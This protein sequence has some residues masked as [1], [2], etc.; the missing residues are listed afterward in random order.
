MIGFP[1]SW[2]LIKDQ[3]EIGVPSCFIQKLTLSASV[4]FI[5]Q[6]RNYHLF[7]KRR[8]SVDEVVK[9]IKEMILLRIVRKEK[10]LRL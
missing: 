5:W 4:Y 10:R 1:D 9:V 6:E 2:R 3:M 8:R 7:R